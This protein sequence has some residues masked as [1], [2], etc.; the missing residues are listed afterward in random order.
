MKLLHT[1][2]WAF[3]A[4]CVVAIPVMA[5]RR[6]FGLVLLLV[7][8]VLV[9]VG[10]LSVNAWRC[11]LTPIAA[12]FTEDRRPNFDI[13]LPE[14]LAKYNKHIFGPLYAAVVAFAVANWLRS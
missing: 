4:T 3:F 2:A 12:R 10:V 5:W 8:L 6:E 14:W 11:P 9:E 7:G 1:A 13:Y